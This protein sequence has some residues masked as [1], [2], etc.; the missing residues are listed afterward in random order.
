MCLTS[1]VTSSTKS[2]HNLCRCR[3]GMKPQIW[4]PNVTKLDNYHRAASC[5]AA[6]PVCEQ[7]WGLRTG[8]GSTAGCRSQGTG[9]DPRSPAAQSTHAVDRAQAGSEAAALDWHCH[10]HW[11]APPFPTWYAH[12][13]Q[14]VL[15]Q[16]GRAKPDLEVMSEQGLAQQVTGFGVFRYCTTCALA[17]LLL[18]LLVLYLWMPAAAHTLNC[19]RPGR[20][21]I[22]L[23]EHL[24]AH[25]SGLQ[26]TATHQLTNTQCQYSSF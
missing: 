19:M 17:L 16:K 23:A 24:S 14:N 15:R 21:L 20:H 10:C 12:P 1:C 26:A 25:V 6:T 9:R 13:C 5:F 3:H 8:R 22:G 2:F 11:Q 7:Q 18:L 4:H